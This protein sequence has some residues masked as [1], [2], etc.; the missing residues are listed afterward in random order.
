MSSE[1][2]GGGG[3]STPT[4]TVQA[5]ASPS[6]WSAFIA[7]NSSD[8][9]KPDPVAQRALEQRERLAWEASKRMTPE[10]NAALAHDAKVECV[11]HLVDFQTCQVSRRARL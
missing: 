4:V 8:K 3:G 2:G 7:S 10:E 1:E 11:H 5:D 6:F 9:P